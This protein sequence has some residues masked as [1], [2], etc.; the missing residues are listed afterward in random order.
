LPTVITALVSLRHPIFMQ[1]Y[2]IFSLPAMVLLAAVG[3]TAL[4]KRYVGVVL[5]IALCALSTPAILKEYQKP[6]EDWRA[7]TDAILASA[8]PGDAVVFFPFY[9]R[10]M[11]D[12]YRDRSQQQPP[13]VHVFDPQYYDGGEDERDL[14]RALDS[15]QEQFRHIWVVLYGASPN[16]GNIEQRSPA[17]ATRLQSIFGEPQARQFVDVGVLEFG[18]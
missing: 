13:A 15:D 14:L 4:R 12:Y 6:R 11:L 17:L 8:Q 16:I 2:L 9:T 10:I 18:K 5:V 7:A 3:M 1:R